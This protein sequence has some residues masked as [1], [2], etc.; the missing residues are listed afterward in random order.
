LEYE[1]G[2]NYE[3]AGGDEMTYEIVSVGNEK[4]FR[5]S[6]AGG[7]EGYGIL[8]LDKW[9]AIGYEESAMKIRVVGTNSGATVRFRIRENSYEIW[10]YSFTDDFTGEKTFTFP[11]SEMTC[12]DSPSDGEIDTQAVRNID[13]AIQADGAATVTFLDVKFVDPQN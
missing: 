2:A 11:L 10:A 13:I 6:K 3:Q 12:V 8:K 5:V 7:S 4:G 9:G 1:T